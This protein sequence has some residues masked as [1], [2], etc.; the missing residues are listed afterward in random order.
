MIGKTISHFKIIEKLPTQLEQVP[1][2]P[3]QVVEGKV[4]IK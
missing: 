1:I 3:G 2:A 4:K